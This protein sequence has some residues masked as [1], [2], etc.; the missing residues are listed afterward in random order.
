MISFVNKENDKKK[1]KGNGR[2][3]KGKNNKNN[4]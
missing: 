1:I 4:Y 3:E 2:K